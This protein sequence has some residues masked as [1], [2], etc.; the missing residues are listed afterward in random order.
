MGWGSFARGA[1]CAAAV[2]LASGAASAAPVEWLTSDGGNGHYY[3][4]VGGGFTWEQA[5]AAASAA[6][7]SSPGGVLAG[8]LATITSA[9]ENQFL[10][11]LAP[12][13]W[14]GGSDRDS[15]GTWIWMDGP[16]AGQVFWNGGPG[17]SAPAGAFA[18]WN[19]GEPNNLGGEN[20][21]HTNNGA[22]ND[23]PNGVSL[24]YY[25]EYSPLAGG[26]PE[27]AAWALMILG[28]GGAGALLRRRDRRVPA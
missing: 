23:Y 25:V 20:Y 4:F 12:N 24:G 3:E 19:G 15:E 10:I 8:Y 5:F 6:T 27:P 11:G 21:G 22:W 26:V 28:F 18:S 16:E 13:G 7:F 1:A 2:A 9:E 17:G 14:F